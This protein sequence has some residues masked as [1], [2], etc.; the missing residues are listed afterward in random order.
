MSASALAF[1]DGETLDVELPAGS[2]TGDV[3]GATVRVR[4]S[5]RARRLTLRVGFDGPELVVPPRTTRMGA[6]GFLNARL[7]WL[8]GAIEQVARRREKRTPVPALAVHLAA[9]PWVSAGGARLELDVGATAGRPFLVHIEGVPP[10]V[11]RHRAGDHAEADLKQLL[12]EFAARTL[13]KRTRELA[14]VA[15]VSVG[16]VGVRDQRHRW[17]SCSHTSDIQLNWRLVLLPPELHD[18]VIFHELA[19]RLH[20]NHSRSFWNTLAGWDAGCARHR[21]QLRDEWNFLMSVAR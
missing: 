8:A 17:G 11:L 12:R 7:D 10:V 16:K 3:S 18:H 5:T 1:S 21:R 6:L 14:A 15:G 13:P 20:M 2:A 4:L 19:H 9:Q